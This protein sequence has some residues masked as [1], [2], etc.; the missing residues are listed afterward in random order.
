M[1]K[2]LCSFAAALALSLAGA[3]AAAPVTM[4]FEADGFQNAGTPYPGFAG[5]LHGSLTWEP[6]DPNQPHGPIGQLL[7]IDLVVGG[8]A[9]TLGEI[10]I[11]NQGS[12]Q[13][14]LGG[15]WRGANVV[16]GDGS[17]DD[18]LIVFN[19]HNPSIDAFAYSLLGKTGAIWWT[20]AHSS[21]RYANNAVSE[22]AP[23]A[24]AAFGA[25]LIA[26]GLRRRAAPA[27]AAS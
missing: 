27:R 5:P 26:A 4:A 14:A 20:P 16:V 23:L 10:G 3:A 6:A 17:G 15:L 19:R 7:A 24:L 1:N 12:H 13:T 25:A 18:F 21:A 22:P 8:H 11:A 9:F 2:N